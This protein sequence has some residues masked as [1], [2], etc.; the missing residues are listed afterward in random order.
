M[1]TWNLVPCPPKRKIIQSKWVFKVKRHPDKTVQK[2]KA[3]LVAMGYSQV[4][5]LDYQEIFEPTLCLET[6]RL[7]C[8]LLAIQNWTGCQVNFKTAFL[9]S[10]LDQPVYVEQP[11]SFKDPLHPDW[12]C[13][14]NRSLYGLKQ[15]PCQWNI[16][17]DKALR[18]LGLSNSK[19]NPTLYFKISNGKLV[20]ALT[21]HVDDLAIVGKHHFVNNLIRDLGKTFKIGADEDLHH[22]LSIE[23]TRD[24]PSRFLFMNQSHYIDEMCTRFL[25]GEHT[26]VTTPTNSLF[27]SLHR[28]AVDKPALSGPYSQL[29]GSMLWVSQCTRPD[30]SFAINR[31]LQ[32]LR[33][34]SKYHWTAT[35][36]MLNYLV[37]TKNLQLRLG[38]ELTCSGYSDSDWAE[39]RD[40]RR[41]TSAYTYRLG[42]GAISWKSRKQATLSLSSTEAEYKALSDSCKEG[43]WIRHILT[44]L[45]LCPDTPIPLHVNN[46]GAKALARNPEHHAR[47]KHIH[48]RYHFICECIQEDEISLLHVS[49]RDMLANMLTKPLTRVLLELN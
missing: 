31:L 27:K 25:G 41:S 21:A 29:I 15:S 20:G 11:P 1:H 10:H 4:H 7:I 9:N 5:G 26:P 32:H 28:C 47:T 23:I 19:Y 42:D 48:A 34:P 8:S 12:V 35:I 33:N 43:L 22:F 16:E 40:D 38:G 36:R 49:T 18:H 17:L 46:E 13:K 37:S 24:Q 39:D 44:E 30:I 3:R 14:V 6:L 2:L 45:H